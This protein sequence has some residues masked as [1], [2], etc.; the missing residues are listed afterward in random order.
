MNEV[1]THEQLFLSCSFTEGI[2]AKMLRLNHIDRDPMG[3]S[4]ELQWAISHCNNRNQSC[5]IFKLSLACTLYQVW[6]ERNGRTFAQLCRHQEVIVAE[7]VKEI[8][9][10][11]CSIRNVKNSLQNWQVCMNWGLPCSLLRPEGQF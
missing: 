7:M 8:R 10:R 1:E 4:G 5:I 3:W 11:A 6:N 9:A 2:W